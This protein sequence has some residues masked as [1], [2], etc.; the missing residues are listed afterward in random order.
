MATINPTSK[1]VLVPWI[2]REKMS[3]P[4]MLVP[5]QWAEAHAFE[6]NFANLAPVLADESGGDQDSDDPVDAH[7]DHG[8][9]ANTVAH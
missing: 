3:C 6:S 8:G 7:D 2:A 1:A 4:L 9:Y 5:N